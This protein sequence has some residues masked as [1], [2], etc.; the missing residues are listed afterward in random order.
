MP[1][2][3]YE[4]LESV[5]EGLREFAKSSDDG[6]VT[7]NVVPEIKLSEFREN[8]ILVSKQR[9]DLLDKVN[10]LSTIVGDDPDAFTTDLEELRK[11]R[12]RVAAGELNESHALETEITKR[13]EG[14]RKKFDEELQTKGREG[15]AWRQKFESLDRQYR[16]NQV[17]RAIKDAAMVPTSGV[18]PTAMNALAREAMEVFRYTDEGKVIP[19]NGDAP[20]YGL[21]GVDPMTPT[22][23]LEKLKETAPFYFKQ[24]H[25]GGAGGDT[26]KKGTF[27]MTTKDL[28]GLTPAQKLD[29]ANM[30]KMGGAK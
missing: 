13:T 22:E 16:Q 6:K 18:E 5:P 17:E 24:S 25:G 21:N 7:V 3:S 9:D 1:T 27:G 8:N 15:A 30:Q 23:W 10:K 20:I 14:M 2:I 12:D 11:T 29:L 26:T 4:T 19:M 28:A